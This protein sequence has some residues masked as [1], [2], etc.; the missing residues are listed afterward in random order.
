[1]NQVVKYIISFFLIT[2]FQVLILKRIDINF[3]RF[4]YFHLIIYPL[5]MMILPIR[6]PKSLMVVIGFFLGLFIDF[7]YDS[8]GVHACAASLT[9]FLRSYVLKIIEPNE[10][11][12]TTAIPSIR[13][14]TLGGFFIYASILL[15]VH[16]LVY[17]SLE[18]FSFIFIGEILLRTIFSFIISII[19]L[20]L[21]QLIFSRR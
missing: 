15:L 7:F 3:N 17:F 5:F 14:F 6:T 11:Y 18:A 1:M 20:M 4:Q 12:N 9:A 8:P 13:T 21:I 2:L 16:L 19:L 10:G